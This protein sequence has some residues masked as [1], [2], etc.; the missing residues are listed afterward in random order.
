MPAPSIDGE[1]LPAVD[2]YELLVHETVR[3]GHVWALYEESSGWAVGRDPEGNDALALWPS[4]EAAAAC[5][6]ELWHASS[7]RPISLDELLDT[8]LAALE[9]DGELV[10][11][12]HTPVRDAWHVPAADLAGDLRSLRRLLSADRPDA[13][14][15]VQRRPS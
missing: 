8:W 4:P 10:A 11:C 9:R 1:D 3:N 2:R 13:A 14:S 5:A 7:P 6:V 12:F 15:D